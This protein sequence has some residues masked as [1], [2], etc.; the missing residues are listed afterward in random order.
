MAKSEIIKDLANSKVDIF[1]ALKRAKVLFTALGNDDLLLWV[2]NEL[3]GYPNDSPLPDYRIV[4][5]TLVGSYLRGSMAY[6][7]KWTKVSIPLGEMPIEVQDA[8]LNVQL[9]ESVT[10]L[11]KLVE[12]SSSEN[13][14]LVKA[15]PADFFPYISACNK[16]PSMVI[17]S[18]NVVISQHII[19][20]VLSVIENML[21]NILIMLEKEFG[22][23]DELD[24]DFSG[25]QPDELDEFAKKLVILLYNDNR[26]SIGDHNR[27]KKSTLASWLKHQDD[28]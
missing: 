8:L 24:I 21:L 13:N 4:R 27:I 16:D 9:F 7:M 10:G 25:K 3:S 26:V 28:N 19:W 5:G 11:H 1:T 12:L 18:A 22:I 23:L 15:V 20:D 14:P 6:H 17:T 2:N